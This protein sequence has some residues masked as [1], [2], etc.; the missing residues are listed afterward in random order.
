MT[1]VD[2]ILA[3]IGRF[4]NR[5]GVSRK[6]SVV[7]MLGT[8]A[9]LAIAVW[10]VPDAE[11]HGTHLQ[12]G[13]NSCSFLTMTGQPCPMCGATTTFTLFGEA[14]PIAAIINQPF[15]ALLFVLTV[16]LFVVSL[17]EVVLPRQRWS[18]MFAVLEPYEERLSIGFLAL[19]GL[20]WFYKAWLMGTIL[21]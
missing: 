1:H 5:P 6:L 10:L 20:G 19:M 11:G 18:R 14:Q 21:S 9:V 3:A 8:G 2:E 4:L 15:A 7:L 12:L 16:F 17:T 13:L